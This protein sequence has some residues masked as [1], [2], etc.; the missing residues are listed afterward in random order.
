MWECLSVLLGMRIGVLVLALVALGASPALAQNTYSVID[1]FGDQGSGE[2]E[3]GASVRD[4][5]TDA[6]GNVWVGAA[7]RVIKYDYNGRFLTAVGAPAVQNPQGLGADRQ[8]NV[9]VA[10]PGLGRVV[11]L[12]SGGAVVRQ[13]GTAIGDALLN[14]LDVAVNAAGVVHV[15]DAGRNVIARFA[16]GGGA[17]SPFGAAGT[18]DS[19][20]GTPNHIAISPTGSIFVNVGGE[21]R[22]YTAEGARQEPFGRAD[23]SGSISGLAVDSAGSVHATDFGA[24]L[25]RRFVDGTQVQTYGVPVGTD[26]Q[27]PTELV[28]PVGVDVDCRGNSY[29]SDQHNFV[30]PDNTLDGIETRGHVVKHGDPAAM[31]PPCEERPLPEG[32]LSTQIDDLEVTQGIQPVRDVTAS[33]REGGFQNPTRYDD[34]AVYGPTVRLVQGR[35]T[36]VRLFA[37]L[38]SGPAGGLGNIPATLEAIQSVDGRTV[39]RAAIQP[40]GRPAAIRPGSPLVDSAR[41]ID[42]AGAY[43]FVLPPE[44]T[45]GTLTLIARVNPANVGCELN[46]RA[47]STYELTN[48]GFHAGRTIGVF[49]LAL[50]KRVGA[51]TPRPKPG[52]LPANAD[53]SILTDPSPAF[54]VARAV[55]P[56]PL[57]VF[58]WVGNIDVTDIGATTTEKDCFLDIE[59]GFLCDDIPVPG[60]TDEQMNEAREILQPR[61]MERIDDWTDDNPIGG[62]VL[63]ALTNQLNG[64]L[65]PGAMRGDILSGPAYGYAELRR[66]YT[67]VAHEFQ[68]A[69]TRPH[70]SPA[71]GADDDQEGEPW[72]PDGMGLLQG[73]GLDPRTGSGG[74][75]GPFALKAPGLRGGPAQ[76]FDLMSYCGVQIGAEND[77]W[78][79]PKGWEQILDAGGG[80]SVRAA[81]ARPGAGRTPSAGSV[82]AAQ[83]GQ[84]Q[85]R[86]TAVAQSDGTIRI[87]GASPERGAPEASD[88]ASP[89]VLE[90]RDA[91]GQ[92]VLATS[93]MR[94]RALSDA[95]G[96][97]LTGAVALTD[98]VRSV[99]VRNT[100]GG[101]IAALPRSAAPPTV[102]LHS[103]LAGTRALGTLGVR[104]TARD[105]DGGALTAAVEYSTN[106]GRTWETI[107]VGGSTGS[108][109]LRTAEL[110]PSRRARVRVR[111]DDGFGE[112]VATSGTF[113]V[114]PSPPRLRIVDPGPAAVLRADASFVLR[115]EG[116][117]GQRRLEGRSLRW[118][119]G[120]RLLGVGS[121]IAVQPLRAGLR[122]I[123]L[124][125]TANGSS[126]ARVLTLRVRAVRAGFL[127]LAALR[128][129]R[130]ARQVRLRVAS[131]AAATLRVGGRRFSV[132][133]RASIVSVRIRPGASTLSLRLELRTPAGPTR[134]TLR[135]IRR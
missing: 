19:L 36:V 60:T 108:L 84:R 35:A 125:G 51:P 132:G 129:T 1:N 111:V 38:T 86:V 105:P 80:R 99:T 32:P 92:Q 130:R 57:N 85:V 37:S 100:G 118:F 55:T 7:G 97:L 128:T 56:L 34:V 28:A 10:D 62:N 64:D 25:V 126:A 20:P 9:Y 16:S 106:A 88:A 41:R 96:V 15:S 29:V 81:Q 67:A 114:R 102:A 46:C 27:T 66:P 61:L 94:A 39:R 40:V 101:R 82:R 103:P 22:R 89:F 113:T 8:G 120:R 6:D 17:M 31:P 70:A 14:P 121:S 83:A 23:F 135:V 49:P 54:D 91:S 93:G 5:V 13:F 44:W 131:T 65:L 43:S 18:P 134:T 69:L 104:W 73:I 72:P 33:R 79:S 98:A 77:N 68:H 75:R 87:G 42:P 21:I 117:A 58:P 45:R 2:G 71:C 95:G 30:R 50:T 24:A 12:S 115:G 74:G 109:G 133:P 122:R 26:G 3:I 107:H 52:E 48:I 127:T 63:V 119:E 4:V 78:I 59:I 124:V 123:R 53:G 90:A 116:S 11:M 110:T 47:R 76:F 112:A